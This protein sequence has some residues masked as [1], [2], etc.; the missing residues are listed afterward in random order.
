MTVYLLHF[1]APLPRDRGEIHAPVGHYLGFAAHVELRLAHHRAGTGARI[2]AALRRRGIGFE[3]ARTW[4]G[5]RDLERRLKNRHE[6]GALCPLCRARGRHRVAAIECP[7]C[8]RPVCSPCQRHLIR[9][10]AGQPAAYWRHARRI[11]C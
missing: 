6:H 7:G 9:C 11:G 3:L 2:T 5:G 4:V 8:G 10:R 1:D